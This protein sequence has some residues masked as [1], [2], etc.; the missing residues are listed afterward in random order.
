MLSTAVC[1]IMLAFGHNASA[2]S[3]GFF[4]D[5]KVVGTVTPAT[6]GDPA[7]VATYINFMIGLSPGGSGLFSGQ[8]ITRTTNLFGSLPVASPTG[9]VTGTG[10][11]LDLNALGT[12]TYLFGQY[13]TTNDVSQVWDI[14]GLT[15]TITIPADGP[16]GQPLTGWALFDPT[17]VPTTPD[18]GS[19]A[20]LFGAALGALGTVRRVLKV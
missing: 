3:I 4:P 15:G 12:F 2:T 18:G 19:T 10:T 13:D 17:G 14:A 5:T 6:P 9:D 11:T 1:A 7:D 20:L 8:S 16:L